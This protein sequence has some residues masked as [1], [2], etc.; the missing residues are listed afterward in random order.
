MFDGQWGFHLRLG[1]FSQQVPA[2][3]SAAARVATV[4]CRSQSKHSR[5]HRPAW[6]Q[7]ERKRAICVWI[8]RSRDKDLKLLQVA[9]REGGRGDVGGRDGGR[10]GGVMIE[11]GRYKEV[12]T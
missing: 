9:K 4:P 8:R 12:W 2:G 6:L 3:H 5:I 7:R 11:R 10:E 1:T